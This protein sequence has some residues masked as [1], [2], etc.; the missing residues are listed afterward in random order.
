MF[1]PL[2]TTIWYVSH[3]KE[4]SSYT[5]GSSPQTIIEADGVSTNPVTVDSIQIYASQRYSFVFETNQPVDNYWIKANPDVGTTGFADGLN[6]AIL[7]YAGAPITD[8][9]TNQATSVNPLKETSLSPLRNPGAPG[10]PFSGGADI[11][12]NFNIT[13]N[14]TTFFINNLSYVPPTVPV[15]L[16]ILSGAKTAQQ[17]LP[18]GSVFVLPRNKSVEVSILGGSPG[19]PVSYWFKC[20]HGVYAEC[21]NKASFPPARGESL[22]LSS[23]PP[24]RLG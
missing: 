21:R 3:R 14:T 16:Q 8:P 11:N 12:C 1:F 4:E 19:F 18:S 7:R 17:L 5:C 2:I 13:F 15:L 20:E 22:I 9:T 10:Q 23:P 24:L 6:S